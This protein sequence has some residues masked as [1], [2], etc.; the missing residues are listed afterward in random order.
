MMF[1]NASRQIVQIVFLA[2]LLMKLVYG[3]PIGEAPGSN[4]IYVESTTDDASIKVPLKDVS[5]RISSSALS[6][7]TYELD[8]RSVKV[9]NA[10]NYFIY[11]QVTFYTLVNHDSFQ[12]T[13]NDNSPLVTCRS[14]QQVSIRQ[15]LNLSRSLRARCLEQQSVANSC[16]AGVV[17]RLEAG[18][19]IK[20][21]R[22]QQTN[23]KVLVGPDNTFFGL[24]KF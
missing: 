8:G 19:K 1:S 2:C 10:G 21:E 22:N 16:F 18:D 6:A 4:T 24:T 7:G 20:I 15:C 9:L 23:R 13:V 11:A 3:T 12:I 14:S 5:W 17:R